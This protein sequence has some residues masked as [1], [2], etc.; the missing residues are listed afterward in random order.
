MNRALQAAACM[1][2]DGQTAEVVSAFRTAGIEPILLKGPSFATWLYGDGGSRPYVDSDLL[3]SPEAL[4]RAEAVL[5][6]LGYEPDPPVPGE[7]LAATTWSRENA[8]GSI[9]LHSRIWFFESDGPVW[10]TLVRHT[11]QFVV[12]GVN[13]MVLDAAARTVHVV[14]HA[15][16]H[17]SSGESCPNNDLDRALDQ[18]PLE[19]WRGAAQV[20]QEVGAAEAFAV[21]LWMAPKARRLCHQIGI[22]APTR[23]SRKLRVLI[24]GEANSGA[25]AYDRLT[26]LPTWRERGAF[27]LRK[28]FPP[29]AYIAF[30]CEQFAEHV[31]R[32]EVGYLYYWTNL[33][34]RT[35]G[36]L[37]QVRAASRYRPAAPTPP[38]AA[39]EQGIGTPHIHHDSTTGG[40]RDRT[41]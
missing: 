24:S 38:G 34:R 40:P 20:A 22:T 3:V 29:R 9:D 31:R 23:P 28:A 21:G 41:A 33:V 18:V 14:T 7:D 12:A 19:T 8:V 13:V 10:T 39:P 2:I 15:L 5:R 25:A 26:A 32:A 35:P 30:W 36:A 4:A 27:L 16:Q 6:D 17:H 37:R 11:E 1:A